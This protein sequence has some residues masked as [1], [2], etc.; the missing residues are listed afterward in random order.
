MKNTI[1]C[2]DLK[3]TIMS[4]KRIILR[5]LLYWEEWLVILKSKKETS[6]MLSFL[7]IVLLS[8]W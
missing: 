6:K 2:K 3:A 1:K 5:G 8:F 4:F 7:H